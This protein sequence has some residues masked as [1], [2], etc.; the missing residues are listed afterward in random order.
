M[1]KSKIKANLRWWYNKAT[2]EDICSGLY[3]YNTANQWC[4]STG[5]WF[6]V[7]YKE[8]ASV[9]SALSPANKWERNKEDAWN[10]LH[11]EYVSG[12]PQHVK[13]CTYN[14]NKDKAIKVMRGDVY[15]KE[16]SPKTHAFVENISSLDDRFVTVDRWHMRACNTRSIKPKGVK[17]TLTRKQYIIV[18]EAT[19]EVA[20][21][22]GL[23]GYE[24]QA[25]VWCTIKWAWSTN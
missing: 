16:S 3:W 18:Q 5:D 22:L 7:S 20:E 14:K 24:L 21:K 12:N 15:I 13:V 10:M 17:T 4:K 6:G 8:V 23:Q 1:N 2:P 19:I 25:I 11:A 9:L